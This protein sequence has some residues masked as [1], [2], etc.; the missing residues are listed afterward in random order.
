MDH[1]RIR[2]VVMLLASITLSA[3]ETASN[4][5]DSVTTLWEKPVVYACPTYRVLKDAAFLVGFKDG[6]G[7]DFVDIDV[8]ATIGDARL[9]CL[10]F[11]EKDTKKGHME[12]RFTVAFGARRGPANKT[13]KAT[14]PYFVSVTDKRRNVLYRETFNVGVEFKGNQTA[15]QFLGETIKLELPLS[16]DIKSTD[17]L[18]YTGFSLTREQLQY[19]RANQK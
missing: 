1:L 8:Q 12:A 14:L 13:R 17:Y 5:F 2:F 9:E 10:T 19:N 3:C 7:R 11:V 4:T 18:I 15:L 16:P 6:S